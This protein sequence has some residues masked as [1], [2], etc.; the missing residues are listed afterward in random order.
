MLLP[1][2]QTREPEMTDTSTFLHLS[3]GW[4]E[5]I[6]T[7][8][9]AVGTVGAIWAALS[10]ARRD[11]AVR[12][13]ISATV[14]QVVGDPSVPFERRHLWITVTNLGRRPFMLQSIGWRS[15]LVFRRW[16]ILG[17]VYALQRVDSKGPDLP[18]RMADG[19]VAN[20]MIP[21]DEWLSNNAPKLIA[22]P[23]WLGLHTLRIAAYASTGDTASS[24]VSQSL[25]EKIRAKL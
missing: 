19:D 23:H 24:K 14:G 1:S 8:V 9:A 3:A 5:A 11:N 20:W 6:G 25:S 18:L 10:I 21:L 17:S 12:I 4:W 15:G 2:D 16:R 13:N 7:W 22:K